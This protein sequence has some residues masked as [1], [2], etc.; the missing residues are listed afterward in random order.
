MRD[1]TNPAIGTSVGVVVSQDRDILM[2]TFT[3]KSMLSICLVKVKVAKLALVWV[4]S[5]FISWR[6]ELAHGSM[7]AGL[8]ENDFCQLK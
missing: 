2:S 5:R 3:D 7:L 8:S 6:V 4:E 1:F